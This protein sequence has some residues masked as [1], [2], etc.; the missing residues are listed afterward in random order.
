MAHDAATLDLDTHVAKSPF[1]Q[2]KK[3]KGKFSRNF[4]NFF[5]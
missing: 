2:K 5:L 4:L 3:K 1:T